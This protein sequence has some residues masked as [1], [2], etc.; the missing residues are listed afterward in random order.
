MSLPVLSV[1]SSGIL[2]MM[3][4]PEFVS[5]ITIFSFSGIFVMA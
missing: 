4:A 5:C 2:L 3:L 1:P